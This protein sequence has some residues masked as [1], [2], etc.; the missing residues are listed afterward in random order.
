M[1]KVLR[2]NINHNFPAQ[3][4]MD[5][6]RNDPAK[7]YG[8]DDE[9]LD[10]LLEAQKD[11]NDAFYVLHLLYPDFNYNQNF[12]QDHLHPAT[13]FNNKEKLAASIPEADRQF[14]EDKKNWNS[15]ANLQLLDGLQNQSKKDSSLT[16]W[17]SRKSISK[18]KLFINDTTSLDIKDFKSFI[19]DRKSI[20]KANLRDVISPRL[21]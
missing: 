12:H 11:S 7:N 10:G 9:F 8:F 16:D 6:F 1:R 21:Q 14:A 19:T 18:S 4:L 5:A 15:V 17:V 2:E 20:L 13:I 3:L